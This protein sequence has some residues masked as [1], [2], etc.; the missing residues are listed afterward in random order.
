MSE[1]VIQNALQTTLEQIFLKQTEGL[2]DYRRIIENCTRSHG[3][4][5]E[6]FKE[7][8]VFRDADY[9]YLGNILGIWL[10]EITYKFQP[11]TDNHVL[12]WR[13]PPAVMIFKG[14]DESKPIR[15]RIR[16]RLLISDKPD[17]AKEIVDELCNQK[18]TAIGIPEEKE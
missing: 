10:D 16:A 17:I 13:V 11:I 5:G 4:T 12:Y 14:E 6:R 18:T 3:R 1:D 15:I 2:V 7:F 9:K 8:V